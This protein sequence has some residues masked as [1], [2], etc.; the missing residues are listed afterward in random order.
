MVRVR[1][2]LAASLA[3]LA[4]AG[5]GEATKEGARSELRERAAK[6]QGDVAADP[7]DIATRVRLA[8][9]QIA[10]GDGVGTEA[11]VKAALAAGANEIGRAHV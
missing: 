7:R 2:L 8:R 9:V 10:L 4:L 11:T 6:L 3:A 1:V 5:C